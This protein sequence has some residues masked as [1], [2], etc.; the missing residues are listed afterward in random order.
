MKV[1]RIVLASAS[2]RRQ[3][4]LSNI[5]LKFEVIKSNFEETISDDGISPETLAQQ[6]AYGKAKDV[7]DNQNEGIILGADTIVVFEDKIYGKP[8][9][10]QDAIKMLQSLSGKTHKVITG[11]ALIDKENEKTIIGHEVTKVTFNDLTDQE[12]QAYV[13]SGDCFGKAGGYGIQ[14]RGAILINRI[15]GCY[16]NVVGLPINKVYQMLKELGEYVYAYWN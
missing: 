14:N 10:E 6:L 9:D 3:E 2:P 8:K 1:R 11:V 13:K 7:A 15:E 12:I 16:F 4:L 5:G